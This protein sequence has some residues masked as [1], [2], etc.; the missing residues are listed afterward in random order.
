MSLF[1]EAKS[2]AVWGG[3][4]NDPPIYG[5]VY[6]SI[7]PRD[8]NVLSDTEKRYLLNDVLAPRQMLGIH[9]IFVEPLYLNLILNITYY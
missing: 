9:P 7:L 1:P 2:I 5:N 4:E 6:L 3:E 8:G